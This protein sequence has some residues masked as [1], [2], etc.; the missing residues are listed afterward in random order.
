[1]VQ[2]FF[3]MLFFPVVMNALQYYIIDGFIKNQSPDDHEPIPSDDSEIDGNEHSSRSRTRRVRGGAV[4][5]E[6][7]E[8]E[9]EDTVIE[10]ETDKTATPDR[11]TKLKVNPKKLDEYNPATDGDKDSSSGSSARGDGNDVSPP[12]N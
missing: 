6:E 5:D 8:S 2:V 1:M 4:Q 9:E 12:K 7:Y 10:G 3:V 11:I